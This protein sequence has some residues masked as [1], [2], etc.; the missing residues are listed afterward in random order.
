MTP[1][2]K[3]CSRWWRIRN[4]AGV[5]W[6]ILSLG[7]L[8]CV[9][10]LVR[11]IKTKTTW[12]WILGIGFAVFEVGLFIASGL[13]DTGTKENPSTSPE[14]QL[15]GGLLVL[16]WAASTIMAFVINRK[17][18]LWKA[19]NDQT[20]YAAGGPQGRQGGQQAPLPTSSG[21][22]PSMDSDVKAA[23]GDLSQQQSAESI[24]PNAR[25]VD[26]NRASSAD[27]Q[28]LGLDREIAERLVLVRDQQNGFPSFEQMVA[29]SGIAP[30]RLLAIRGQ[31]AFGPKGS[32]PETSRRLFD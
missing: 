16:N 4:S 30:H 27:L 28:R 12:W 6:P 3:L 9:V 19:H 31:L 1:E 5:L 10:F 7:L 23:F 2:E 24:T 29:A 13:V 22:F 25:P 11:G 20:W 26:I 14:S 21:G 32:R 15:F 8:G 17:W 18:L